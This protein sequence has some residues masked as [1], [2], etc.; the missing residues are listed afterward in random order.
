MGHLYSG[1]VNGESATVFTALAD[2]HRRLLLD[3]LR[4]RD[5]QSLSELQGLLPMT[6][7]GVMKHLKVL[8]NAG[9]VV[10]RR[11]GR[12]KFH[13]L[14]PVPIQ[15]VYDRWVSQFARPWS[16]TLAGIKQL[17]EG[18]AMSERPAHIYQAFIAAPAAKVWEALTNGEMTQQYYFG[19]RLNTTLVP[20]SRYTY[21]GA[22]GN[23]MIEGEIIE[24]APPAKL[25]MTFVALF[26]G[27]GE[28]TRVT[29]EVE[30]Q[31][32]LSKLTLTHEGMEP[33]SEGTLG[34]QEGWARI[35]SGMKTLLETG[36]AFPS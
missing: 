12:E 8:E 20:G 28:P 21:D 35:I 22:D 7:F 10:T 13:Y 33:G 31:G 24:A 27:G 17:A 4:E 25:V 1:H 6:R 23:P 30:D 11:A 9:L 16:R 29:W 15:E 36:K 14:N 32:G 18:N 34:I 2:P 19:S 5:G 3:R 26:Q